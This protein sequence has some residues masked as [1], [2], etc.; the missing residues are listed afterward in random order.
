M[1][2]LFAALM[3]SAGLVLAGLA[4]Y[5]AWRRG[6]RSGL[7]LAVLLVAV[8]WWGLC[9]AVELTV[10]PVPDK[11]LWGD[12]KYVGICAVAPAWFTFVLQYTGRA[13][14]VT[15]GLV[16]LLAVE[17]VVVLTLLA[18]HATHH[19]V[20][21]YPAGAAGEEL[22][23]VGTGPVFWV[24]LAYSN[25]LILV[26]TW[27]FVA[28]MV[29]LA[30]TYRRMAYVLVAAALLPWVANLLHNFEVGPFARIDLTPFAFILTGGVL[31]WGVFRERLVNLLPLA[32]GAVVD[33][34]ADPVLVVDAFGR[35]VDV[36][37]AAARLLRSTRADLVGHPLA[38]LVPHPAV[39]GEPL[40][41]DED[42]WDRLLSLGTDRVYDVQRRT[43]ADRAGRA[44]GALVV[45]RDITD[46][47]RTAERLQ[48]LLTE[49][50][51]VAAALQ[52]SMMPGCL[53]D[54][55]GAELASRFEPAGDGSEIGGDFFDVFALGGDC[56]G[57][58]L[59]DVSGKGAE[60][61]AVTAQ[62]RYTLRAL[63]DAGEA[64]SR[65][66]RRLHDHLLSTTPVETH[67]TVVYALA[68]HTPDGID[69]TV[70]LAGHHPPLVL[71]HDGSVQPV[72]VLGSTLGL[73][74]DPELHDARFRLG[75][76]DLMC[77]FTD[78]LV[79]ASDGTDLFDADRV[80]AVLGR[81]ADRSAEETAA[82]LVGAARRFHRS[83]ALADDL[84]ILLLRVQGALT[85][86]R[87]AALTT[88]APVQQPVQQPG[89]LS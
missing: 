15:R 44:A 42:E 31:V 75:A 37:P 72:G 71:R 54:I 9:Y 34:M 52:A 7:S 14:V 56:W 57:L 59:G 80:S 86:R 43:L 47:V 41:P 78:G 74:E 36:N 16:A 5:V 27:V 17:P 46:R 81:H 53:P 8:A 82:E 88:P 45:F 12:L 33:S 77:L 89:L 18:D 69:L 48:Q 63:A 64:P 30:R 85:D 40:G 50:S 29:R 73:F 22:P 51:R 55:P 32:R 61:A 84:A 79:E 39:T 67:C 68:R 35:L 24:H 38:A 58:V 23:V 60:A 21:S 49:Q 19:L 76:G 26:A 83:D 20:H 10:H 87:P 2:P 62:A 3:T 13:H 4:G 1:L 6:S 70:C 66:L 28:S 65:T 25:L 11:S